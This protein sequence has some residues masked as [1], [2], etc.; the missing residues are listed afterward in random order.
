MRA[1]PH[2][3]SLHCYTAREVPMSHATRILVIDDDESVRISLS[4]MLKK[5]GHLAS[6]ASGPEEARALLAKNSFDACI[7]DMNFTRDTSGEEGLAFLEELKQAH[8]HLP[9][10]LL[11]AWGS[12]ALAVRGVKAGAADFITKP[13]NNAQ[14][15]QIL[16]TAVDLSRKQS[17]P[18]LDREKLDEMYDFSAIIGQD[19]A[20]LKVLQTIGRVA[21]TDAPVL[22]LGESG[23]GKELIAEALHRNS[24][25]REQAFVK[26]NLGGVSSGLFESEM[27]GHV[28]GAFT[29]ARANRQGRFLKAH[30]GSIF[31]DEIGDLDPAGQVKMLRVLQ[32]RQFEPLG[33]SQSIKVDVRVVSATN[34]DL[35]AMVAEGGFREDLLYRLNLITLRLP[36]L[37][38]RRGDIPLLARRFLR[39]VAQSYGRSLHDIDEATLAWLQN[40]DWP[41]NIRQLRQAVE[42][43]VLMASGEVLLREHFQEGGRHDE[44]VDQLPAVGEMTLDEME[45]AMVRKCMDFYGGNISKVARALGLS[46]AALYRRLEKHGISP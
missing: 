39:E 44:P 22:I 31:L 16:T 30:G 33:S 17:E 13:W 45:E 8:P 36:P 9:V 34:R 12:I 11:T 27:F 32:D 37:R 46:R 28:K 38:E 43:A 19:P 5:A 6:V 7:S 41:G 4:M 23:C 26:V 42:R 15:L 14:L 1:D 3:G 21:D 40:L 29:D 35:E 18:A 20:L 10:V 2:V 25:R 24:K